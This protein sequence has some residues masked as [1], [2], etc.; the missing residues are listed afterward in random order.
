MTNNNNSK[1]TQGNDESFTSN[2]QERQ[3]QRR[4]IYLNQDEDQDRSRPLPPITLDLIR[5]GIHPNA[6]ASRQSGVE[7]PYRPPDISSILRLSSTMRNR[8]STS[9]SAAQLNHTNFIDILDRALAICDECLDDPDI[10][11][12]ESDQ[13]SDQP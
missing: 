11:E 5:R 4:R 13:P 9:S 8:S 3:R 1:S 12:D 10:V 7:F 2:D 6:I